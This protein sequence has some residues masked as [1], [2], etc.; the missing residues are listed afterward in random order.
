MNR[1]LLV[2]IPP[3]IALR[4]LSE[5]FFATYP[6]LLPT[7]GSVAKKLQDLMIDRKRMRFFPS[8][9]NLLALGMEQF[10]R[11]YELI[12]KH[13]LPVATPHQ[14]KTRVKNI[15]S[16]R[17]DDDNPVRS[18]RNKKILPPLKTELCLTF[19][20]GESYVIDVIELKFGIAKKPKNG[21]KIFVTFNMKIPE[22][23]AT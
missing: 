14:L 16:K 15:C 22:K 12:S 18:V 20:R 11:N 10:G 8:E 7:Q 19:P 21:Y 6:E 17:V 4:I 13:L 23:C 1:D 3:R 2:D 5:P 9:D